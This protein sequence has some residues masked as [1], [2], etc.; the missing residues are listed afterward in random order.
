MGADREGDLQLLVVQDPPRTKRREAA[1]AS[2]GRDD[3]NRE[4]PFDFREA[5]A[6][7]VV[8]V[9]AQLLDFQL[10]DTQA[11]QGNMNGSF[12]RIGPAVTKK[13]VDVVAASHNHLHA[14]ESI[15]DRRCD[16]LAGNAREQRGRDP[17]VVD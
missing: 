7:I 14:T 1:V 10:V 6:W 17:I 8:D 5:H 16:D 11:A 13:V 4:P 2:L 3:P 15:Q 9:S 12:V